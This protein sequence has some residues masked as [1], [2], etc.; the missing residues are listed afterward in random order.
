MAL[1]ILTVA[2][3]LLLFLPLHENP[4]MIMLLLSLSAAFVGSTIPAVD[5]ISALLRW[6]SILLLFGFGV[7]RKR[8]SVS[9]G[10]LFFWGYILFGLI[11]LFR[12]ISFN[13]QF[14]RSLLL[15]I[16]AVAIPLAY[17][18]ETYKSLKL[19]LVAISIVAAIFALVNFLPLITH[20]G[21]AVRFSGYSKKAP[22]FAMSL[23]AMLPFTFW[24][25][26]EVKHKGIQVVCASGFFAGLVSL[27]LSGQ[28]TG[29]IVGLL[30][31]FPLLLA[32][33]R[34]KNLRWFLLVGIPPL[35][36]AYTLIQFPS[37]ER[38]NFLLGRYSLDSGL[39]DRGLIWQNSF[40]E[41]NENP[42]MGRGIGA[43]ENVQSDSFHNSY[44]E[45]WFNTGLWGLVFFLASQMYFLYRIF[46]LGRV[47][48]EPEITAALA[49]ALGYMIGFIFMC[50]FES[51]G[52]GASNINVLLFLFVG[53]M[54][55]SHNLA[56]SAVPET[57]KT[58][59]KRL[60]AGLKGTATEL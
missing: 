18:N 25:L 38:M 39:S 4:Y 54:L 15:L 46:L 42:L 17:S 27:I 35:L 33:G 19:S 51:A 56:E 41:I 2:G 13:W 16:V 48:K 50:F 36:L 9:L 24:G 26:W 10:L 34:S 29:T 40:S 59:L 37:V 47:S 11:F 21:E 55:S 5:N 32:R 22:E 20:L 58:R 3:T 1:V 6:L 60:S 45:V 12:A 7:L 57:T 28:R 43:A 52:A 31:L 8:M 53:V 30:G 49:L 44:L 23:G 14:Q